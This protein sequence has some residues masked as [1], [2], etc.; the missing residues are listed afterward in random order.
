[1]SVAQ[2]IHIC[3]AKDF[4]DTLGPRTP[5]E[6]DFS[7]E[8]FLDEILRPKFEQARA[9]H[10]PLLVDL[11]GSEGYPTSFLQAAFGGLARQFG[12]EAVLSTLHF[13]S[14]DEPYLIKEIKRYISDARK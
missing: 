9:D 1:M 10:V 8:Q 6:G 12:P 11:D 2:G 7:G 4:S 14:D 5:E 3:V 13:K